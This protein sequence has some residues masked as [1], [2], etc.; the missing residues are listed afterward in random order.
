MI[1]KIITLA[2]SL[3]VASIAFM[4]GSAPAWALTAAATPTKFPLCWGASAGSSYIRNI[5]IASQIGIQNGAA[6]LTDGY[7]PLTFTPISAGGVPPF[8]QDMNGILKQIT[9]N[10]QWSEAGAPW[11][12]D[13]SFS[14][15]IGGYPKGAV[16]SAGDTGNF[17]FST[18]D[19]NTS[20]PDSG[21]TN[22]TFFSP[23]YAY[24]VDSGTANAGV[25]T[26]P[27]NFSN[28]AR[29]TGRPITVKKISSAN[30]GTY[31][32]TVNTFTAAVHRIDGTGLL[33]GDLPASG[34]FT[35]IY[36]GT[37]FDL[38]SPTQTVTLGTSAYKTVTDN[39][40]DYVASVSG[41]IT[42]GHVATFADTL[43]TVQDGGAL[44]S[45]AT[46][47]QMEAGSSTSVYSSPSN[48][49]L[50]PALPKAWVIFQGQSTNG[51]CVIVASFNVSGVSRTA[52]GGYSIQTSGITL[53]SG[54]A[55]PT[56]D[57]S[58]DLY[59][60]G[61]SASGA[62]PNFPI[63]FSNRGAGGSLDPT[64]GFVSIY[65]KATN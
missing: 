5:P 63:Q 57:Q 8:G 52:N 15:Y 21:G 51:A 27:Y 18:A 13:N 43:G 36:D 3:V 62:N 61:S 28:L 60:K 24:A 32:L 59:G 47:A 42:S 4:A 33:S 49:Y 9:C 40:K 64:D 56:A 50:Q 54:F 26:L 23:I 65:G 14:T 30:T 25:V 12:Y 46:N 2:T 48:V 44:P 16:L 19:N 39:S 38:Q 1:K 58:L 31:T 22:W 37:Y 20:D 7:P 6:S 45:A 34:V 53:S 41:A 11:F 55:V 10:S 29:I 17:W 35:V